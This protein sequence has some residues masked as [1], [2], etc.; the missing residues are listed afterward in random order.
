MATYGYL[1]VFVGTLF[2]GET[3]LL[4]GGYAAHRGHLSLPLV[5]VAAFAGSLL[6]DQTMFWIGHWYGKRLVKRWPGLERRIVR[7]RPLLDR[8]G[9]LFALIFRFLYGLRNAT[10]LAMAIGG[11]PARRFVALNAV[12][13]AIWSVAVG[14]I[15]YVFGEAAEAFLPHAHSYQV[16]A[17]V[18][19]VFAAIVFWIVR[20]IRA[21]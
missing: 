6:G 2:E 14:A 17:L 4:L 15:G 9:N 1:A 12:G 3:I 7:V 5:M 16:A 19:V 10:P 11:F 20:R 8:F 13:A 18:G 21:S